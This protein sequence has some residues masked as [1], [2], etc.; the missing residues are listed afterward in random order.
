MLGR[1]FQDELGCFFSHHL[2][3]AADGGYTVEDDLFLVNQGIF[4]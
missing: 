4:S 2:E 1:F 3:I